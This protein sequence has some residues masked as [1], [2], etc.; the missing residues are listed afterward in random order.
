MAGRITPSLPM[1]STGMQSSARQGKSHPRCPQRGS[2]QTV[3]RPPISDALDRPCPM[4]RSTHRVEY[5]DFLQSKPGTY[6]RE[7]TASLSLRVVLRCL[8]C[9]KATQIRAFFEAK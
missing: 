7:K 8:A 3:R 1:H 2:S 4:T 6:Y 5:P 9:T